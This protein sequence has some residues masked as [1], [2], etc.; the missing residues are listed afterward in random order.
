MKI[1][2][3]STVKFSDNFTKSRHQLRA[4]MR[5]IYPGMK[6]REVNILLN[7]YE[8]GIAKTLSQTD[9][10]TAA[11]YGSFVNKLEYD[12]GMTTESAI[13][14]L[15]AWLDVC[16]RKGA[17]TRY[18]NSILKAKQVNEV[19]ASIPTSAQKKISLGANETVFEDENVKV[20]FVRWERNSY[21]VGGNART[22][23]F[24][25]ENKSTDRLCIYMKDIAV[26]GFINLAESQATSLNAKQKEMKGFP[27]IY[28]S[29]VP[30]NLNDFETVEFKVC[31]GRISE[32]HNAACLIKGVKVESDTVSV[33][34]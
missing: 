2:L 23:Y 31:Y 27:F 4:Y 14:A 24:V 25:F 6:L 26:D 5:D 20:R 34:L 11:Q 32:G 9:K 19:S 15:N 33:K 3:E 7:V 16:I 30:G 10:I 21:L 12:Y 22:G 18:G 1:D 17:G 8:S 29:K 13:E 28:E